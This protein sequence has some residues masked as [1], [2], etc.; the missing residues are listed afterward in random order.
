MCIRDSS[1]PSSPRL[2]HNTGLF[3][4]YLSERKRSGRTAQIGKSVQPCAECQPLQ[5]LLQS[6]RSRGPD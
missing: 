5:L 2:Q 6:C 3:H 4:L 1:S